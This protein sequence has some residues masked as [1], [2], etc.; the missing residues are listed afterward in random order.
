MI[1]LQL[2][3]ILTQEFCIDQLQESVS[4]GLVLSP[5]SYWFYHLLNT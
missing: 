3:T 2:S 4:E 1:M 5:D